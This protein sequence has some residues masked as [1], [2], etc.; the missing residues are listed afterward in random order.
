LLATEEAELQEGC[1]EAPPTAERSA[2]A[3][4]PPPAAL[5]PGVEPLE[6]AGL[7]EPQ[8]SRSC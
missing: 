5:G 1:E 2:A 6:A 3:A 4:A 8:L 7:C